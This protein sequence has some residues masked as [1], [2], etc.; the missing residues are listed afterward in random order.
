MVI[1]SVF[2]YPKIYLV[3]IL[4]AMPFPS[5]FKL[6]GEFGKWSQMGIYRYSQ[7]LPMWS[8]LHMRSAKDG[9]WTG[10]FPS[11]SKLNSFTR[12]FHVFYSHLPLRIHRE[13]CY[14]RLLMTGAQ[15]PVLQALNGLGVLLNS[16]CPISQSR[17]LIFVVLH[18]KI[19][20]IKLLETHFFT[21][22]KPEAHLPQLFLEWFIINL[23]LHQLN[24]LFCMIFLQE[25]I[26]FV[27]ERK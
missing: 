16:E 17:F 21:F 1:L 8:R 11:H 6:R 18:W 27:A 25:N 26:S 4:K 12:K 9:E 14:W 5:G 2:I 10:M 23:K 24:L 20:R 7:W 22:S 15:A 3:L 13:N 19:F